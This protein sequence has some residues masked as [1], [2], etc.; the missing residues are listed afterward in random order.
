MFVTS[1]VYSSDKKASIYFLRFSKVW[2]ILHHGSVTWGH[3]KCYL[4]LFFLFFIIKVLFLLFSFLF[5]WWSI[6]LSQQNFNQSEMR[7]IVSNCQWNCMLCRFPKER[8]ISTLKPVTSENLTCWTDKSI[9]N[10]LLLNQ[11]SRPSVMLHHTLN[12]QHLTYILFEHL[13][14]NVRPTQFYEFYTNR[15]V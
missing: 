9:Y 10:L 7:M 13:R 11:L 5:F 8:K 2:S 12:Y 4:T 14:F 3:K 1:G 6:K 15:K